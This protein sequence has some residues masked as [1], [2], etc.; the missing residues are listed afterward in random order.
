PGRRERGPGGTSVRWF[1]DRSTL[2][3]LL[4]TFAALAARLRCISLRRRN[5][6]VPPPD[7]F[8]PSPTSARQVH[9]RRVC[10]RGDDG[11]P[12]FGGADTVAGA[13]AVD[14]GWGMHAQRLRAMKRRAPSYRLPRRTTSTRA[15]KMLVR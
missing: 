1:H 7:N 2:G 9:G 4:T 10:W 12:A 3:K 5:G 6:W 13:V 14:C 15:L 11:R 8:R